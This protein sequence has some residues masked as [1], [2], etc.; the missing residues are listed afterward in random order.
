MTAD[1]TLFKVTNLGS[2]KNG[3]TVR[4]EVY[5]TVGTLITGPTTSGVIA[6]PSGTYGANI[7]FS[8]SFSGSI[9]WS[10]TENPP[11]IAIEEYN[12]LTN[13]PSIQEM[14]SSVEQIRQINMG[15]WRINNNQLILYQEDNT[16]IIAIFNLFDS[17]AVATSTN[18]FDRRRV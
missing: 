9:V 6:L 12:F 1:T 3:L 2:T 14:S 13:N 11:T 16:T 15:R 5:N 8:S 4:Y 17:G 10:T 7:P 18:P